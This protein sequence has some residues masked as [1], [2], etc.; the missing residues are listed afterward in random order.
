MS[1]GKI[2]PLIAAGDNAVRRD[3][4][5]ALLSAITVL[6]NEQAEIVAGLQRQI[7]QMANRERELQINVH[8]LAQLVASLQDQIKER[9]SPKVNG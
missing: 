2:T 5:E 4:L 9:G 6:K 3:A 8:G 7:T 1:H